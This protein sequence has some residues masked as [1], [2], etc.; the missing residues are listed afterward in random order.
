MKLSCVECRRGRIHVKIEGKLDMTTVPEARKRLL[1]LIRTQ[2]PTSVEIDFSLVESMDTSAVAMM[3]EVLR[4]LSQN[5]LNLDITGM[6]DEHQR[7]FTLARLNQAF[8]LNHD[9]RES[10]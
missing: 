2:D 7:L 6:R 8:G 4:V 10:S 9:N 5:E 1:R 3:V